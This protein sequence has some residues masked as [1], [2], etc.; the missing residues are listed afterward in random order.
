M[1]GFSHVGGKNYD[2]SRRLIT[3]TSFTHYVFVPELFPVSWAQATKAWEISDHTTYMAKRTTYSITFG[4]NSG[5]PMDNENTQP[6]GKD[7]NKQKSLRPNLGKQNHITVSFENRERRD[8]TESEVNGC[9]RYNKWTGIRSATSRRPYMA[10]ICAYRLARISLPGAGE[11]QN[12]WIYYGTK[13]IIKSNEH[14]ANIP[15]DHLIYRCEFVTQGTRY[16]I[17]SSENLTA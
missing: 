10:K 6:G 2:V 9:A 3:S 14:I 8:K 1:V 16:R 15:I 11:A 17:T 12:R 5:T 4:R 7:K 13:T